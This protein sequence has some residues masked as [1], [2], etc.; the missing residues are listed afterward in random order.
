MS[1]YSGV[2][3]NIA[4]TIRITAYITAHTNSRRKRG[5]GEN[6][7]QSVFFD[8]QRVYYNYQ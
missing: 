8:A 2:N 7:I 4:T 6:N 1:L 3:Y 5:K